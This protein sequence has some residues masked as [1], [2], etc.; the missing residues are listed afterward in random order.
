MINKRL[1][2]WSP[3][4]LQF[5][6]VACTIGDAPGTCRRRDPANREICRENSK[7]WPVFAKKTPL[8][9]LKIKNNQKLN[10]SFPAAPERR[11]DCLDQGSSGADRGSTPCTESQRPFA[12]LFDRAANAIWSRL[13]FGWRF[14]TS[15]AGL[16]TNPQ[17]S[18]PYRTALAA[19]ANDVAMVP[20][21]ALGANGPATVVAHVP[22]VAL[23]RID[24]GVE[25]ILRGSLGW[26][27]KPRCSGEKDNG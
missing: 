14:R 24:T 3:G 6:F 12:N 9:A 27:P 1:T 4:K 10:W 2:G 8:V 13:R 26:R 20:I 18:T 21:D 7:Y 23:G 19:F 11:M 5:T 16:S 22:P 15:A 17:N 25:Q